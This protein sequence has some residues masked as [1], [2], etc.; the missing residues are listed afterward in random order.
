[1]ITGKFYQSAEQTSF[2]KRTVRRFLSGVFFAGQL[3]LQ[4]STDAI[5]YKK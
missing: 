3:N 2:F 1:M 4:F 5:R